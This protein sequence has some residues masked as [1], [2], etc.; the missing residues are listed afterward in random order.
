ML[1]TTSE[2]LKVLQELVARLNDFNQAEQLNGYLN[3]L[4]YEF[5]EALA[6]VGCFGV[7]KVDNED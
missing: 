7:D 6:S 3:E 5:N 2:T 1:E 4:G